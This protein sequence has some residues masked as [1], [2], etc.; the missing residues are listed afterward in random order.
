MPPHRPYDISE[1]AR[2]VRLQLHYLFNFAGPEKRKIY[3]FYF[4]VF[5]VHTEA[6][7]RETNPTMKHQNVGTPYDR[8]TYPSAIF[9]RTH[10][11]RLAV[12]ALLH[13][14][15]PPDI[16]RA[17][18][19]EMGC[20]DGLNL[21]SLAAAH[22]QAQFEGFDLSNGSEGWSPQGLDAGVKGKT[23]R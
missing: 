23:L 6:V 19:L 3:L 17:R 10:P 15:T 21:C 12:I 16:A 4:I 8:V 18:T 2:F 13:G 7:P 1:D 14:L 5:Q 20:G 11:D 9:P 22:P